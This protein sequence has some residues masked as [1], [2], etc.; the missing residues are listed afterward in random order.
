MTSYA[1][2]NHTHKINKHDIYL[3]IA[4]PLE[5]E[6]KSITHLFQ[7]LYYNLKQQMI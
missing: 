2:T 4:F 7:I 3:R 6:N 1:A 5:T